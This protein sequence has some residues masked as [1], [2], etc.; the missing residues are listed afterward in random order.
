MVSSQHFPTAQMR[1]L[2]PRQEK[3]LP[4]VPTATW[5][6]GT[7]C[8]SSVTRASHSSTLTEPSAS[9]STDPDNLSASTQA[10]VPPS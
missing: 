3:W 1:K 6:Q 7:D 4:E 8:T 2:R 5:G 10:E 9:L